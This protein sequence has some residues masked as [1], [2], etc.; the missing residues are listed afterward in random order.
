MGKL[1]SCQDY[2]IEL[3]DPALIGSITFCAKAIMYANLLKEK[4]KIW[5]FIPVG[6]DGKFLTE[7]ISMKEEYRLREQYNQA[8]SKVLFKGFEVRFDDNAGTSIWQMP[9][10]K[11]TMYFN[12]QWPHISANNDDF[13][14]HLSDLVKYEL[15]L[16]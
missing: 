5:M 7:P 4:P 8:L 1:I 6:E 11:F 9:D 3:G 10:N 14:Y 2:V 12:K 15:E 16:K 13:I